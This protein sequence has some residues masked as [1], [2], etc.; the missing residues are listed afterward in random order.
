[1]S[2]LTVSMMPVVRSVSMAVV[3]VISVTIAVSVGLS[4]SL[5]I[6]VVAIA[7]VN[8][9]VAVFKPKG[10]VGLGVTLHQSHSRYNR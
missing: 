9:L 6:A 5:V 8:D 2:C 4:L 1:M 7:V 3:S 10:F